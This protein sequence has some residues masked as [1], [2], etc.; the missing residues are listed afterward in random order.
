[1]QEAGHLRVLLLGATFETGNMGVSALAAG[2]I[3][4]ILHEHPTAEVALLDY[5]KERSVHNIRVDG[6]EVAINLVNMRFSKNF[7]LTNNIAFLLFC[8]LLL[9]AL[10]GYGMRRRF[11]GRNECLRHV[12]EAD[13]VAAIS[14]GDSF[15]DIYGIVRLL[16]VS[17]PQILALWMGKEL[18][19][20]PQTI[21]PFKRKISKRIAKYILNRAQRVYSRDKRGLRQIESLVGGARAAEKHAFC[22]DVAFVLEPAEPRRPDIVGL[23]PDRTRTRPL[24]GLNVSGLL[25]MGG[26]TRK[27]M[28]GLQADYGSLIQSLIEVLIVQKDAD[29]LLLPHVFGANPESDVGIC[30]QLLET[31]KGKYEGRLGL[32]RGNY[33]QSEIKYMIG[34]CD[35]LVGSRMHACIAALS[36]GVPAVCIAYS[37]KFIGVMETLDIESLVVDSR[38]SSVP[39]ILQAVAH[40]FDQ[41]DTLRRLL[42]AKM[43]EVRTTVLGLFKEASVLH[44]GS[45]HLRTADSL[46]PAGKT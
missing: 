16:Y 25:Y 2:S 9:K 45:P 26:Y 36:Q 29:V 30:E 6:R 31:L 35:F 24:V 1:M 41:R 17:F 21:G 32:L 8:A 12:Y 19:L 7:Y 11:V 22:Y 33:D 39:E 42:E 43:P 28:F 18:I 37:D 44:A 10:P 14:G 5:A 3:K 46:I 23:P 34:R 40:A 20:L 27:N 4:C 38:K 13:V 15:S